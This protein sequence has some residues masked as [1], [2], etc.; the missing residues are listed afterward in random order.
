MSIV[1]YLD[2]KRRE[3]VGMPEC[4]GGV[5]SMGIRWTGDVLTGRMGVREALLMDGRIPRGEQRSERKD[6]RDKAGWK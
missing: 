1:A 2:S 6:T 5:D 3:E 4:P